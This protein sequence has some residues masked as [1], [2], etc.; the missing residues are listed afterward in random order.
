MIWH[1]MTCTHA[2]T[3]ARTHAHTYT[4]THTRTYTC[5]YVRTHAHTYTRMYVHMHVRSVSRG[6]THDTTLHIKHTADGHCWSAAPRTGVK[7]ALSLTHTANTTQRGLLVAMASYT[8]I[9]LFIYLFIYFY[10]LFISIC[11]FT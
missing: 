11:L 8:N 7:V 4:R 5:T 3:H 9:H 2:R 6:L 10:Y 1:A